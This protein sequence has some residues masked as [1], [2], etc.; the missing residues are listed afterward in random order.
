MAKHYRGAALDTR[1]PEK[2]TRLQGLAT[3]FQSLAKLA[4]AK[5][6]GTLK[7]PNPSPRKLQLPNLPGIPK[8]ARSQKFR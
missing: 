5:E 3:A 7:L 2:K 1:N 4:K 8:M 6:S